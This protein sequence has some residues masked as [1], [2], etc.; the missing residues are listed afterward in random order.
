V[1]PL[2]LP[3][4]A[5]N[6]SLVLL[7]IDEK[8]TELNN[9]MTSCLPQKNAGGRGASCLDRPSDAFILL[10]DLVE[11]EDWIYEGEESVGSLDEEDE[12][13]DV[14][15][16]DAPETTLAQDAEVLKLTNQLSSY[17]LKKKTISKSDAQGDEERGPRATGAG[18]G[19]G[20]EEDRLTR[21]A[22]HLER[23]KKKKKLRTAAY[24]PNLKSKMYKEWLETQFAKVPP[25]SSPSLALLSRLALLSSSVW[26]RLSPHLQMFGEEMMIPH[27]LVP[28]QRT[29]PL[30]LLNKE[31]MMRNTLDSDHRPPP[32][33]LQQ[34]IGSLHL[35]PLF[36]I[37]LLSQNP[38]PPPVDLKHN[39]SLV[40]EHKCHLQLL[41]SL[42]LSPHL[43][44]HMVD[45]SPAHHSIVLSLALAWNR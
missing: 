5:L 7:Q 2:R 10:S 20:D 6:A 40:Q 14:A 29:S 17:Q 15:E 24:M 4:D 1:C 34:A 39:L 38:I 27:S 28:L 41:L 33:P 42:H 45:L 23:K 16:D 44:R 11:N 9:L 35:P 13:E 12:N 31:L 8:I 37:L 36:V 18:A 21:Y 32:P 19:A 3:L 26:C 22:L 43:P 30:S 25:L